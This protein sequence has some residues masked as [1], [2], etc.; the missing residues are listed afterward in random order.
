MLEPEAI[1][2]FIDNASCSGKATVGKR[3]LITA[4]G[5]REP[6]DAVRYIGNISTG[7]TACALAEALTRKGHQ[8]TWLGAEHV[9]R[10]HAVGRVETYVTFAELTAP[11]K[12]LLSGQAFDVVVHAAAV[13]D[14]SVDRIERDGTPGPIPA[15]KL[16]SGSAV[17]LHLK[18]NPK[19]LDQLRDWSVNPAIQV[20]GFK[21]T[22]GADQAQQLQAISHLF[23][24][25]RLDAVVHND[26]HDMR[27][28]QH[29]FELHTVTGDRLP[30]AGHA[31]LARHIEDM[32]EKMP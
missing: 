29:P 10:P 11:L 3:V 12:H 7:Q 23:D 22:D 28:G 9:V 21:L 26:L 14:F 5:T 1:L 2:E 15:T 30:C 4:G 24:A 18:P 8:V 17:T 16:P 19:L 25:A 31:E 20:I 6:I 32:M 13:G 27:D